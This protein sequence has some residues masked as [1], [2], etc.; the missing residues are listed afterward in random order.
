MTALSVLRAKALA[1]YAPYQLELDDG[2]NVELKSVMVLSDEELKQFTNT[3]KTLNQLD[4]ADDTAGV[5]AEFVNLIS[6]VSSD[7]ARTAEALD[8][9]PLGVLTVILEEYVGSLSEGTKS[10][11]DS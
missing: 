8:R 6:G 10:A 11:G 4:E 7:R 1:K 9:E 5:K 3:Q 2:S